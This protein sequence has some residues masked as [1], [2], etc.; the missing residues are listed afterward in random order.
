MPSMTASPGRSSVAS[1]SGRDAAAHADAAAIAEVREDPQAQLAAAQL[2]HAVA[3]GLGDG[4]DEVGAHRVAAVDEHVDHQHVG[5]GR[6]HLEVA[7]GRRRA[8]PGP[9][10]RGSAMASS[11]SFVASSAASPASA[12]GTS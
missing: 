12:S 6:P 4:V 9:A 10:R 5:A 11:S 1:A 2:G 3:Q 7:W 8:R